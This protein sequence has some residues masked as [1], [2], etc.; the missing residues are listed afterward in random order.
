MAPGVAEHVFHQG[1]GKAAAAPLGLGSDG[2]DSAVAP[3]E[4]APGA[5][6]GDALVQHHPSSEPGYVV[7]WLKVWTANWFVTGSRRCRDGGA[8]DALL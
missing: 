7:G 4:K 5:R 8:D 1:A 6:D 3:G 2:V